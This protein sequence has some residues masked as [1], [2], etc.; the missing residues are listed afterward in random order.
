MRSSIRIGVSRGLFH[1]AVFVIDGKPVNANSRFPDQIVGVGHE[2]AK[3]RIGPRPSFPAVIFGGTPEWCMWFGILSAV[4]DRASKSFWEGRANCGICQRW[5]LRDQSELVRVDSTTGNRA[6]S[7]QDAVRR[8]PVKILYT[9][10]GRSTCD[11]IIRLALPTRFQ[12]LWHRKRHQT[13]HCQILYGLCRIYWR[14][15]LSRVLQVE[16]HGYI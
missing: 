4:I 5:G 12:A 13:G 16:Q 1:E 10:A 15:V 7:F 11:E 3:A 6:R 14:R 8:R 2:L 9:L